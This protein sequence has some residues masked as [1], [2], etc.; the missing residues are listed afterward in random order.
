MKLL[1]S[2]LTDRKQYL[3]CDDII[4]SA[5][6]NVLCGVSQGSVLG[7]LLFIIYINDIVNC[8]NLDAVLFADDAALVLH[9]KTFKHLPKQS[10]AEA[11]KFNK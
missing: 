2:Y 1:Q 11:T 9:H 7:P 8:S 10:I 4:E 3:K 6:I 5:S